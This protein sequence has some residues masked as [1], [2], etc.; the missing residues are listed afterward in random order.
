M[1]LAEHLLMRLREY[2]RSYL[3]EL[4]Y[5]IHVIVEEVGTWLGHAV[6][7]HISLLRAGYATVSMILGNLRGELMVEVVDV[8]RGSHAVALRPTMTEGDVVEVLQ[9][10][11]VEVIEVDQIAKVLIG[12]SVHTRPRLRVCIVHCVRRALA[13]GGASGKEA[14]FTK[15][16]QFSSASLVGL[17]TGCLRQAGSQANEDARRAPSRVRSGLVS[18]FTSFRWD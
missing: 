5:A 17:S 9:V 7:P 12:R 16:E 4:R 2:R 10:E 1:V 6:S 11:V 15:R 18:W 13:G 3:T 8:E 14:R